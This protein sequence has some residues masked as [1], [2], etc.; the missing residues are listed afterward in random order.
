M[1]SPLSLSSRRWAWCIKS[2]EEPGP[3]EKPAAA[4]P[5]KDKQGALVQAAPKQG[6]PPGDDKA[7]GGPVVIPTR[8]KNLTVF[9]D[10]DRLF[11]LDPQGRSHQPFFP[12]TDNSNTQFAILALWAAQRHNVPLARTLGHMVK[13]YQ[14]SQNADGSWGYHYGVGSGA[15]GT[16]PMTCVGL[17]GLAVG[18]GL[19]HH[20]D[21]QPRGR[22]GAKQDPR[23]LNGLAALSQHVG[24]PVE[25]IQA[26]PQ[27]NLY[28]LWS[29]ERVGV[30]Y[31]L[32]TIGDKDWYRWGAQILVTNQTPAGAWDHGGYHAAHP[33]I[34]TCLALLFLKRASLVGDLAARLPFNPNELAQAVQV[35]VEGPKETKEPPKPPPEVAAQK[36]PAQPPQKAPPKDQTLAG[37]A[38]GSVQPEQPP[39]SPTPAPYPAPAL[40]EPESP[41]EKVGPPLWPFVLLLLGLLLLLGGGI[42]VAVNLLRKKEEEPERNHP[43][44]PARPSRSTLARAEGHRKPQANG[45]T[46]VSR[47]HSRED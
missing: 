18:H 12:T 40:V 38:G 5:P 8:L 30:L 41:P 21:G 43:R 2:L 46:S 31:N 15:G 10:P 27:V 32:A 35:K 28:L 4:D 39:Q 6:K 23:I 20:P 37:L 16:G 13:R 19:A 9:I 14:V 42:F 11:V 26:L 34:D 22:V 44:K 25:R 3:S 24:Q 36:P 33:V 17:L 45:R 7:D 1:P 47:G 29:I